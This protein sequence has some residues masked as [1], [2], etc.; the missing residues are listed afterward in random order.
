MACVSRAAEDERF[1]TGMRMEL[2]RSQY[3]D[4]VEA[5]NER[6]DVE[7]KR[8][9]D[10]RGKEARAKIAKHLC[11]LANAGGGYLV[12]GFDDDMSP[13]AV[14]AGQHGPYDREYFSSIVKRYLTPPFQVTVSRVPSAQT[15]MEHPVI[16]IPSHGV[17]PVCA[18]RSGPEED[19]KSVGVVQGTHY[20]RATGPESVAVTTPDL[21][22]PIIRRC[23]LHD[24]EGLLADLDGL[25][26][27]PRETVDANDQLRKWHNAARERFLEIGAGDPAA[28]RLARAHYQMSYQIGSGD[29]ER[30]DM[31][32]LVD[33]LRAM[34]REVKK[35]VDSGLSMFGIFDGPGA[36]PRS[37]SAEA[38]GEEEFLEYGSL[39]ASRE[40]YSFPELWRV[41]PRGSATLIRAYCLEDFSSPG[42]TGLEPGAAEWLWPFGM[43]RELAEVCWHAVAFARRFKAAESVSFRVE[44]HGLRGRTLRDPRNPLAWRIG[45]GPATQDHGMIERTRSVPELIAG[46]Q[47]LTAEML[48]RVLRMFGPQVSVS[49]DEIRQWSANAF[50][51]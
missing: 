2:D 23:V 33:E 16:W 14:P 47:T 27:R 13:S 4:L 3:R 9:M 21:W 46:W 39:G 26:Q 30:L 1:T 28:A 36:G 15:G 19:G 10:L 22:R 5:P 7:Y 49:A 11:A 12:F 29:G 51:A 6:A 38:L 41:S 48:S 34:N 40:S 8:W 32:G 50:R 24:R 43:G 25:L 31:A 42:R 17:A 35:V 44:W 45:R 37:V 20:T 18:K